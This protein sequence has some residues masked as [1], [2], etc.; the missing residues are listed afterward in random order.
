[1]AAAGGT[2]AVS[3]SFF[4]QQ[5]MA[6]LHDTRRACRT[7]IRRSID[8]RCLYQRAAAACEPGLRVVLD[9]NV[10]TLGLLVDD[11]Q[12]LARAAGGAMVGRGSWR[13]AVCRVAIDWLVRVTARGDS[14]WI[15]VL[16]DREAAL[17][18]VFEKAVS[19]VPAGSAQ[20]LCRQLPR[21][22]GLRLDMDTLAGT[23]H[24]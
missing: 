17:L 21:L 7:L 3:R 15:R 2:S 6:P 13:G 19:S 1:M 10:Q 22:Y 23:P 20:V 8:L 4:Q 24:C 18:H 16:A 9:E 12:V 14:G 5:P 11:L